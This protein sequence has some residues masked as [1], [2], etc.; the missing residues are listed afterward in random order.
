MC[1]IV[2]CCA[3][4]SPKFGQTKPSHPF[5]IN[6]L[7]YNND[8]KPASGGGAEAMAAGSGGTLRELRTKGEI[9]DRAAIIRGEAILL[10]DEAAEFR[11]ERRTAGCGRHL[12]TRCEYSTAGQ[13]FGVGWH[14]DLALD[15]CFQWILVVAG[16]ANAR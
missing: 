7:T 11:A 13:G 9:E 4:D 16:C 5:K 10:G 6:H 15:S 8:L 12:T 14:C 3:F 2:H 1:G